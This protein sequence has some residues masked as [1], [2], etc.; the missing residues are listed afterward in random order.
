[1]GIRAWAGDTYDWACFKEGKLTRLLAW[2]YLRGRGGRVIGS[3]SDP[4]PTVGSGSAV[5]ALLDS[6][7]AV[8][9]GVEWNARF[10]G[11]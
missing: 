3:E 5:P 10:T 9:V 1:M 6:D 7:G 2:S 11:H 4:V 8:G